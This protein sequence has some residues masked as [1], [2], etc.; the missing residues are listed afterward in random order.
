MKIIFLGTPEFAVPSLQKLHESSDFEI[1]GVF[2]EPDRPQGRKQILTPPPVKVLAEKLKLKIYQPEKIRMPEWIEVVQKIKPEMAIVVAFGQII[3]KSILDVPKFG[4]LNLHPSLLPKYRGASPIQSAILNGDKETGIS[5]M[6][7]D[8]EMDHGPVLAQKTIKLKGDE[9]AEIL[10]DKLMEIG[11][12]LLVETA[13][14]WKD[15]KIKAKPQN[16]KKATYIKLLKREDGL[17]DFEKPAKEMEQKIRAYYPWPGTFMVWQEKRLKILSASV[18]KLDG[19]QEAVSTGELFEI[20]GRL[21]VR[22]KK[23]ALILE[24]VQLE[25]KSVMTGEEFLHGYKI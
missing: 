15:K 24:R 17:L 19:Y 25:G 16:H 13:K 5:I 10:H 7:L 20:R 14:N 8:E 21:A 12:D 1:A 6:L 2:C 11:A 23:N 3:P 22:C 9:T 4:F 18:T